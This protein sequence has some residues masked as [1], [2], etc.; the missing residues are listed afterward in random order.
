MTSN[1]P[2]MEAKLCQSNCRTFARMGTQSSGT[3]F[4]H[5]SWLLRS[6]LSSRSK[7]D[8]TG[9]T[10]AKTEEGESEKIAENAVKGG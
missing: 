9:L 2:A 3:D 5:E 10:H 4:F 1:D 8:M 7:S 6:V